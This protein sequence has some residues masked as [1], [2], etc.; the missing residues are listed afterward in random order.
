VSRIVRANNIRR[1][2]FIKIGQKL[3]IPLRGTSVR[4]SYA[5]R[6]E[7]L[8]GGKYRIKKGDSLWLIAR[9]FNTNTKRLQRLNNLK[10][11]RLY[12]GQVLKI[13]E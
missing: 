4:R 10:S 2:H 5:A 9:K 13:T 7:L 11:T 8:P 1:K 12:V 6:D 3:R